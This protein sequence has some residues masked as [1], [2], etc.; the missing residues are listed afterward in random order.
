MEEECDK[1]ASRGGKRAAEGLK[2]CR[3]S[4]VERGLKVR[5]FGRWTGAEGL[6]GRSEGLVQRE[7]EVR[8][9]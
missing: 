1:R 8:G 9:G 2:G 7:R 5:V 4:F 6:K 3:R